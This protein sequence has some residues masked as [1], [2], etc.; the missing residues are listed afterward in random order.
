MVSIGVAHDVMSFHP[1][2]FLDCTSVTLNEFPQLVP[3]FEAAFHAHM[4]AW[5][6]DGQP[7]PARQ[8]RVEK[9][10][11]LPTPEDRFLFILASVKTSALQVVQGRLFGM[12]QS[13]ANQW[14]PILLPVW[15]AALRALGDAPARSLTALAQRLGV[16]EA[17]AATV[18]V[19]LEEAPAPV[20]A[21]P[22]AAPASPPPCAHDG[23]ERRIVRPHDPV[24]QMECESGKKKDLTVQ[25]VLLV[26]AL[27]LILFLSDTYGGRVHD[28]PLADMTPSPF[29]AGSRLVQDLGFLACTLPQVAILMPTTKPPQ[30]GADAGA[31]TGEPGAQPA[32]AAH[33]ARQ[34]QCHALPHR[35]R[36]HPTVEAGCPRS[37]DGDLL[38]PV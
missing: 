5:R 32:S 19:P 28:T 14:M 12:G 3:P 24:E 25:N 13:T 31:T 7:R 11:P 29:P 8:L 6:L 20:V 16:S 15:L 35:E 30:P 1:V 37:G 34:Q 10:C 9:H 27:L 2:A 18:V 26:N 4:A 21:V 22:A 23:T 38:C 33:R 17:D 36:P